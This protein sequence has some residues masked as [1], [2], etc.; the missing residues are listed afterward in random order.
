MAMSKLNTFALARVRKMWLERAQ[1]EYARAF[2]DLYWHGLIIS[3]ILIVIGAGMYGAMLFF[4]VLAQLSTTVTASPATSAA[5][6][7][8][9]VNLNRAT[10]QST[11]AAYVARQMEFQALQQAPVTPLVDPSQ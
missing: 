6:L 1:P 4:G 2:A 11:I 5:S 8:A 3:T 10:L 9:A 7:P